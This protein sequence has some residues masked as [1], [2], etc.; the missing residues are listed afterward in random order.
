MTT[1]YVVLYHSADDVVRKAPAHFPAHLAR[2]HEFRDRGE[3]SS[4]GTFADPQRQGAM[5]I[6]PTREAAEKFVAGD[7]FQ[8]NGVI[9]GYEIREWNDILG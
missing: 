1:R 7:P 8:L 9:R 6:F 5:A 3:I 2:I 4:I